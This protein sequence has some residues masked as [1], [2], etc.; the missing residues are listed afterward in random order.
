LLNYM[1]NFISPKRSE[2][3]TQYPYDY[4]V[5]RYMY[6]YLKNPLEEMDSQGQAHQK[7]PEILIVGQNQQQGSKAGE[8]RR[9]VEQ[10]HTGSARHLRSILRAKVVK[11]GI[12]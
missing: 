2:N 10:Q 7:E 3:Q 5:K 9:R 4:R 1:I 12:P 6:T 8:K 11:F